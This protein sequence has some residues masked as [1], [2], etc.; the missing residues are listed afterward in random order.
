MKK[1][2][3]SLLLVL[4]LVISTFT[5]CGKTTAKP[6][7]TNTSD[8]GKS[9]DIDDNKEDEPVK[10]AVSF[11][12]L[13][14]TSGGDS[15]YDDNGDTYDCRVRCSYV[16]LELQDEDAALYPELDAALKALNDEIE[17]GVT[18]EYENYKGWSEEAKANGEETYFP[19]Y[20]DRE[21]LIRRADTSVLSL[22]IPLSNFS[23]GAHGWYG[24]FPRS[25]DVKT[26]KEIKFTDIVKD[27][28]KMYDYVTE[29]LME[30]YS[31]E[32]D[33]FIQFQIEGQDPYELY[34]NG[35][36]EQG[37]YFDNEGITVIFNP[38]DL[39]A[40]AAGAQ[41]IY[42]PYKG[43][44]D[45]F[46]DGK[47][48]EEH[49]DEYAIGVNIGEPYCSDIF[50]DGTE[51]SFSV[52]LWANPEDYDHVESVYFNVNGADYTI[53]SDFYAFSQYAYLIRNKEGKVFCYL[54][55]SEFNDYRIVYVY[56]ITKDGVK[57]VDTTAAGVWAPSR[58]GDEWWAWGGIMTDP[59]NFYADYRTD[60]L[61]TTHIHTLC[62]VGPDGM[63]KA[64]SDVF[65]FGNKFEL[66]LKQTLVA[67]TVSEDGEKTGSMTLN[68]GDVVKAYRT[69]D[70]KY[71]DLLTKDGVIIRIN[72]TNVYPYEVNGIQMDELFDGI[73]Y[74]G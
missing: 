15:E 68:P 48:F 26:G 60:I 55:T 17:T 7:N 22:S 42:I 18:E 52:Y 56:E 50:G 57:F 59:N 74:A 30:K 25:F 9:D 16:L 37:F 66:T 31:E 43:N 51:D 38:Y 20:I 65:E 28:D 72:V 41:Q 34:K 4:V 64:Y 1:K 69:D 35:T 44:E 8:A 29:R 5:A 36:A 13:R 21:M 24:D 33:M 70:D 54:M 39:A 58:E 47:Y 63:P 45:L 12:S 14:R 3:V 61:G 71:V 2:I 23:G 11:L 19:Y 46:V 40:Y 53:E 27:I 32:W 10:D 62:S 6:D 49:M 67:D 73:I